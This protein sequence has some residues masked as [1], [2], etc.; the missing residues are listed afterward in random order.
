MDDLYDMVKDNA[1]LRKQRAS[2]YGIGFE[3]PLSVSIVP[4]EPKN[5]A[6]TK[7]KKAA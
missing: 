2:E 7:S 5:T 3:L 6:K 4:K 1:A